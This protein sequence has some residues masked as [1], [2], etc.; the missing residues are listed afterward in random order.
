MRILDG[1]ELV[2]YIKER[3]RRQVAHLRQNLKIFPKLVIVQTTDNPVIDTFVNLKQ[4]YGEDLKISVEVLKVSQT[5]A[6]ETIKNLNADT[7]VQGI[8]VQLPLERPEETDEIVNLIAPT[9]D[10]DGLGENAKWASATATAIDW[11][12]AGYN[13]D[14]AGKRIVLVGHGRLVGR[15]LEKLWRP[16]NLDITIA[17]DQTEDL[18]SVTKSG[19]II[20]TA[21]GVPGLIKSSMVSP[22]TVVVDA[23][24]ASEGGQVVGD[25]DPE[26]RERADLTITP[27]KGGVGP[28]TIAALFDNLIQACLNISE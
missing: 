22:G 20:I 28:L 8:I 18:T 21:T 11:L 10:I 4:R 17:D 27:K 13:V 15:P 7:T 12:L 25:L 6:A 5:R 2:G 1:Q 14:L 24:T 19:Q 9:K 3:Q 26:V 23:G 16:Q